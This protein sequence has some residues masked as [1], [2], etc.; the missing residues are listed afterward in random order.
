MTKRRSLSLLCLPLLASQLLGADGPGGAPIANSTSGSGASTSVSGSAPTAKDLQKLREQIVKQQEEIKRLQQAVDEQQKALDRAVAAVTAAP[1]AA[2]PVA[3]ANASNPANAAVNIVPVVNR[4]RGMGRGQR[5]EAA[6]NSPLG[7]SIGNTTLTPLGFLD[8]TFFARSTNVG[9]GIGTNFMGIPYNNAAAGHLSEMNFSAQNSRVGF[10]VD[11]TVMGAQ[12]LGYLETDFLFNNDANSYQITSNSAGLRLRNYFVDV[13]KDNFEVLAGQDWSFLT[14][15]RKGLS[16]LPSDIFYT[17]NM[18]TNYQLGLP[19][20]RAPQ[21]RFIAHPNE[22]FAFGAALENP[23]QYIGG[24]SGAATVSLPA[25]LSSALANQFSSAQTPTA[26]PNQFPDIIVKAAYDGKAGDKN[27]HIEVAGL[28]RGFKDY[29]PP[30]ITNAVSGSHTA[31]GYGVSLNFNLE[32]AKNFRLVSNNFFSDGGGRY[33]FGAGPDVVVRPDGSISPVHTSSTVSGFEAQVTPNILL[34]AYYGGVYIGKNVVFDPTASGS[35]LLHPVYV[36]YGYPGSTSYRD[37]QEITF[38][39]VQTLWKNRN[40]GALSLINQY[41]YVMKEPW[42]IPTAG[43]KQ[44]HSNLFY[45]D[46]RYTLP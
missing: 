11:S 42:I 26:V 25:N 12:V 44:A 17:Q 13:Q 46:L 2:V 16:P 37:G 21:F 31:L 5:N 33:V 6:P 8:A 28:L 29:V 38:D 22:N 36:G 23:F 20:T 30:T 40:Y 24:G 43:P 41:S 34:A 45:V 14:P 3:L 15:N 18:D 1:A 27:E 7:I 10:R 32:L 39:W 35:T 19:W 9:S 4:P